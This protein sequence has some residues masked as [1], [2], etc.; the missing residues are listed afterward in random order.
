MIDYR[1][2]LPDNEIV[3]IFEC[4]YTDK[5]C[6]EC[7]AYID[8]RCTDVGNGDI[9][10]IPRLI[11]DL[12][13]RL[14]AENE[15]FKKRQKP[16]AASGYKI[17][18]GKVVFYVDMLGYY[19][20]KYENLEEVVKTLN[21]LLQECYSKDE[22]VFALKCKT[23]ELKTAKS[24]AYKEFAERLKARDGYDN[25]NFDDSASILVPEEYRKGRDEK[26]RE[27]WNTID[28]LLKELVGDTDV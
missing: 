18:N 24:E 8:E 1:K 27:V 17:E 22:I 26:I 21:E 13:N 28:N 10:R 4:C 7:P 5:P 6:E 16:T 19:S 20:Y 9:Y 14:Q 23:E 25:H 3:R 2:K 15:K 11:A 12:I